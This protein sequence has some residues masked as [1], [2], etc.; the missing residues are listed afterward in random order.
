MSFDNHSPLENVSLTGFWAAALLSKDENPEYAEA[1]LGEMRRRTCYGAGLCAERIR[2]A[3]ADARPPFRLKVDEEVIMFVSSL[4]SSY[5][6]ESFA[7][8]DPY[9]PY[10]VGWLRCRYLKGE[11]VFDVCTRAERPEISCP[12]AISSRFALTD[13]MR[14]RLERLTNEQPFV[15][16]SSA[17]EGGFVLHDP[18][19]AA[20]IRAACEGGLT[21]SGTICRYDSVQHRF[22]QSLTKKPIGKAFVR[23]AGKDAVLITPEASA[24]IE[25]VSVGLNG[26]MLALSIDESQLPRPLSWQTLDLLRLLRRSVSSTRVWQ[27]VFYAPSIGE[28]EMPRLAWTPADGVMLNDLAHRVTAFHLSSDIAPHAFRKYWWL[29]EGSDEVAQMCL[30]NS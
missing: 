16:M 2:Q 9:S 10:S 26:G 14:T 5:C 21:C 29:C 17:G 19:S 23:P 25:A 12:K 30:W 7:V 15:T 27:T 3:L 1:L 8:A 11:H 24:M 18:I 20:F 22:E 28:P 13:T 6:L 4:C